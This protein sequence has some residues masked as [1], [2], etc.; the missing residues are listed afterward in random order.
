MKKITSSGQYFINCVTVT[1]ADD[2]ND[3]NEMADIFSKYPFV[4]FGILLSSDRLGSTRFPSINWLKKLYDFTASDRVHLTGHNMI[5]LS[6]HICGK[7]VR[8]LCVGSDK[9]F[10]EMDPVWRMFRRFQLNF[11]AQP[12][13]FLEDRC[14]NVIKKYLPSTPIIVQIDG[15]ND[16][17]L[18]DLR[19]KGVNAIPL[20]DKSSGVGLLPDH[21]P[22]QSVGVYSGYAGGLSPENLA[23]EIVKIFNATCGPI[24]IDA[25][26]RLRSSFGHEGARIGDRFDLQK[27]CS[28]LEIAKQWIV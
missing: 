3:P 7:W 4:E 28:F 12:H 18:N 27:V 19:S 2:Y 1:G 5:N 8:E 13:E 20:F 23:R 10:E 15:V 24:W 26:T 16:H 25:E 21:W 22:L 17:I 9:F 14:S 6:G 11:H